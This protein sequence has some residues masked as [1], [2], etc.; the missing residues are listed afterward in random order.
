MTKK[1]LFISF[2][3]LSLTQF[4]FGQKTVSPTKKKLAVQLATQTVSLFPIEYFEQSFEAMNT[5][6]TARLEKDLTESLL[7]KMNQADNLNE[8]EK[9]ILKPRI[10]DFSAKISQL[11]KK[12][13][14]KDFNLKS[15]A[16][17][18]L[19]KNY[20]KIFTLAELQKLNK[21]FLT[22]NGQTF[23]KSFNQL[24]T[25]Q[26][27]NTGSG[28]SP[29]EEKE[30]EAIAKSLGE[31]LLTKLTDLLIKETMDDIGRYIENWGNQLADN[32]EKE[33]TSGEIKKEMDKFLA[34]NF[35]Q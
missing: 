6:E 14:M 20:L 24:V 8:A 21:F 27:Q 35:K 15:T 19:Q 3:L 25:G 22:K 12:A 33:A 18:S 13:M 11:V 2:I 10:T 9:E 26:V 17:N 7:A 16:S 5:R 30:F 1:I 29:N 28:M 34:E 4:S 31:K 32:I 23:V